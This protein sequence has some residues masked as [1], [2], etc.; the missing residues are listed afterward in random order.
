MDYLSL[1]TG[2][3]IRFVAVTR[4][5]D[6]GFPSTDFVTGTLDGEQLL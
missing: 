1:T 3:A 6:F 5:C 2:L 4:A